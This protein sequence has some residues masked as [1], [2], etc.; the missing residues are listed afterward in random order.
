MALSKAELIAEANGLRRHRDRLRREDPKA[1]ANTVVACRLALG[2]HR[3]TDEEIDDLLPEGL[4]GF[5][6]AC[7]LTPLADHVVVLPDAAKETTEGGLVIPD[8]AKEVPMRGRVLAIGPGAVLPGIG[9]VPMTV[10]VGQTVLFGRYAGVQVQLD[11]E[12]V[13]I[14]REEDILGILAPETP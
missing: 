4:E 13:R 14:M 8:S 12:D 10:A 7:R 2:A 9:S 6:S 11:G 5:G 3:M 1:Y